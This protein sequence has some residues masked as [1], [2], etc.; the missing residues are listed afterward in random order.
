MLNEAS[1]GTSPPLVHVRASRWSVL[2]SDLNGTDNGGGGWRTELRV[3]GR[4]AGSGKSVGSTGEGVGEEAAA[5][6]DG[7]GEEAAAAGFTGAG[8][9]GTGFLSVDLRG[10]G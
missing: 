10:M 1:R 7:V 6:G 2:C 3:R 5:A 4:Q 9:A 8:F